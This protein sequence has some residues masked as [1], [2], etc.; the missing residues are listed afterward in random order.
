MKKYNPR[1]YTTYKDSV[2]AARARIKKEN[3]T[4]LSRDEVI[5][6]Y[7]PLVENIAR[8]FSTS[9]QASGIMSL[10]DIIQEGSIGL[11]ASYDN[12]KWDKIKESPDPERTIR[13]FFSKRIKGA[14][15]RAIDK[16]R[17]DIRIPEHKLNE[18]R[19]DNGK[20]KKLM[21]LFFN[22]IFLSIDEKVDEGEEDYANK[23][24]DTSKPYVIHKINDYLMDLM[25]RVL[26]EREY[27]VVR[28]SYGLDCDKHSAKQIAEIVGINVDTAHVRVS[29]IKRNALEKLMDRVDRN[30]LLEFI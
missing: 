28:L 23:V 3:L 5:T 25:S 22:S 20:D 24:V 9:Q 1:T 26:D 16:N 10:N 11:I 2:A 12:I 4:S 7:L 8:K 18:I 30:M 14:I 29:Q 21:Q 13:S 15:R 6:M 19:K 27:E 17:G